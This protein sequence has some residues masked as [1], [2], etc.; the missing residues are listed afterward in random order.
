MKNIL[1]L[2]ALIISCS[3]N[4]QSIL[5]KW[6]TIDDET[7]KVKSYVE[8]YKK[9]KKYFGKVIR[10]A[11][12][13]KQ[14]ALCK[15]CTGNNKGRKVLGLVIVN[16]LKKDGDEFSDGTILDPSS[17]KVYDCSMWLDE[18]GDLQVRGYIA[19]FFRTQTW[20]RL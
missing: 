1:F 3:L 13:K 19:F 8:I 10:I 20:K 4:A 11:N 9:G 18:S 6:K 12:P 14:N 7:G 2:F 15:N 17:G 16:N 5:G